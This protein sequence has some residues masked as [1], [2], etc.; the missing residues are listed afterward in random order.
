MADVW[1]KTGDTAPAIRQ[2]LVDGSGNPANLEGATVKFFMRKLTRP[3]EAEPDVIGGDAVLDQVDDGG[4]GTRGKV[5]Y[6]F[7]AGALAAGGYRGEWQVTFA[8]GAIETFP[9]NGYVHIAVVADL[10]VPA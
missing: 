10:G 3:G 4:D 1:L 7:E 2:V 6:N 9:N 5:H 8:S